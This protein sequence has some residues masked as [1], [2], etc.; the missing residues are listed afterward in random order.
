MSSQSSYYIKDPTVVS[1][2]SDLSHPQGKLFLRQ[3]SESVESVDELVGLQIT[4]GSERRILLHKSFMTNALIN[5]DAGAV[6]AVVRLQAMSNRTWKSVTL[7]DVKELEQCFRELHPRYPRFERDLTR[8]LEAIGSATQSLESGVEYQLDL[9]DVPNMQK[10][11]NFRHFVRGWGNAI[12]LQE[13]MINFKSVSK[14]ATLTE[15]LDTVDS[16]RKDVIK[17]RLKE[18]F[19][20][21]HASDS[22][23]Q[24][25]GPLNDAYWRTRALNVGVHDWRRCGLLASAAIGRNLRKNE[26]SSLMSPKLSAECE[27]YT[28]FLDAPDEESKNQG[29]DLFRPTESFV[30]ND[31]G[32]NSLLN[33]LGKPTSHAWEL[34]LPEDIKSDLRIS[35]RRSRD[36]DVLGR[37]RERGHERPNFTGE[38]MALEADT[39]DPW[40]WARDRLRA[41]LPEIDFSDTGKMEKLLPPR[42]LWAYKAAVRNED[43]LSGGDN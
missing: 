27:E 19:K 7:E 43:S 20:Q 17:D 3:P 42:A 28:E 22:D 32:L 38:S 37:S 26:S 40:E 10:A 12:A 35:L 4:G 13:A 2:I 33:L 1:E 18:A 29:L 8:T 36:P 14:E 24:E 25:R 34:S 30:S 9:K 11:P 16:D 21:V 15:L 6:S 5:G 41:I 39:C 23:L 31:P